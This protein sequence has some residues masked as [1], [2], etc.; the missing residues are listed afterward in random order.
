MATGKPG[1]NMGMMPA[2]IRNLPR[3]PYR[4]LAFAILRQSLVDAHA[5]EPI[6]IAQ[7]E[8]WAT[9]AGIPTERLQQTFSKLGAGDAA[10]IGQ[11]RNLGKFRTDESRD[12]IRQTVRTR[13]AAMSPDERRRQARKHFG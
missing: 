12:R 11:V 5:G 9:L 2:S 1:A 13:W 6:S 8:P 4:R 3:D 10:T 7:L